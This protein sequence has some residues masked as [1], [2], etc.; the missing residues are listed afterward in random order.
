MRNV[1]FSVLVLYPFASLAENYVT[2]LNGGAKRLHAKG[3]QVEFLATPGHH[4]TRSAFMAKLHL[5]AQGEVPEHRDATE[6]YIYVL[7][8]HGMLWINDE[9]HEI[10]AGS[11]VYMPAQALVKFVAGD[12]PVEVLQFFAPPGPEKKYED[13]KPVE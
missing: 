3:A 12:E 13:W 8:G 7:S 10:K 11:S 4:A 9:K 1:V 5:P 2:P 6:E